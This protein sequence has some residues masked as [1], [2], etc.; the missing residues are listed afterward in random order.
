MKKIFFALTAACLALFQV[1]CSSVRVVETLPKGETRLQANF[2]GPLIH[3][4]GTILPIPYT[5]L[6]VLHGVSDKL[7]LSGGLHLTAL[8][9]ANAQIDLGA[10]Y[11]LLE[12]SGWKPG[13]TG[14]L[15]VNGIASLR[16]GAF[17]FYPEP[18]LTAYW[19]VGKCRPYINAGG[20][21]ELN[22]YRSHDQLQPQSMMPYYSIGNSWIKNRHSWQADFRWY[23]PLHSNADMVVDYATPFAKGAWGLFVSYQLKLGK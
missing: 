22:K 13:L 23:A 7:T 1:S 9:Y 20:W 12:P 8:A 16:S 11:R 21:V 2:G 4:A 17:R 14:G 3:F 10:H 18:M 5:S 19:K 6:G 15:Q